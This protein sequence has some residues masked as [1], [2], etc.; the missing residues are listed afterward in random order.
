[1]KH[2]INT[3]LRRSVLFCRMRFNFTQFIEISHNPN[4]H[5]SLD[6]I[7]QFNQFISGHIFRIFHNQT[8]KIIDLKVFRGY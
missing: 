3:N 4:S 6:F 2:Y 7:S 1:M 8:R 5:P